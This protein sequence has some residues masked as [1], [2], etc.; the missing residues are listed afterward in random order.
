MIARVALALMLVCAMAASPAAAV[1]Y[2][3]APPP[4]CEGEIVHDYLKPFER[5]PKL[6]A[7]PESEQL[8]FAP[9]NLRLSL[10]SQLQIGS[11]SVG[12]RLY[13]RQRKSMRL[14]WIV[15]TTFTAVNGNGHPFG[16]T[17][18]SVQSVNS[19]NPSKGKSVEF[20]VSGKPA[21][22]RIRVVFRNASGE[23]LGSFGS[24][25]RVVPPTRRAQLA[26]NAD[27]Y[28]PEQTV[29]GR[30]EN[31]GTL[32]AFYGVPYRIDRLEGE[33]WAIA[34]ESPN[35][36][37]I[38]PL[39]ISGPGLSGRC[40]GFWIPPTMPP[41]RYRMVKRV[42]IGEWPPRKSEAAKTLAGEFDVLP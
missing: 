16:P 2:E 33:A 18:Q 39:L 21:F 26:T 3:P 8:G 1:V 14:R 23:K 41:G 36:P 6:H 34:P 31:F 42:G 38:L 13:P 10:D 29:F 32:P 12:Y 22:Y 37:W 35:G 11:G 30:I 20:K 28:R 27:G 25:F 17:R 19:L 5:M 7:P 40:N 9:K 24:Y 4:F 15:T